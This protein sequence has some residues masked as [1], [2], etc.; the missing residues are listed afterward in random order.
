[1]SRNKNFVAVRAAYY[2]H[3]EHTK[4]VVKRQSIKQR[5]GDGSISVTTHQVPIQKTYKSAVAEIEHVSRTGATNSINV[6][7]QYSNNNAIV[8]ANGSISLID[9][10]YRCLD[11][12]KELTKRRFRSDG[13]TLFEHIVILSEGHVSRLEALYGKEKIKAEIVKSLKNYAASY[14]AQFG[15]EPLGFSLHLDEGH[16][17]ENNNFIRNVHAHVLFF[18]Y[19]FK[20]KRSN[21]KYLMK[22]GKDPVTGKTNE[23]NENFVACQDLA[24]KSFKKLKFRRGI[25]KIKTLAINLPKLE[26]MVRKVKS[27][28]QAYVLL[29]KKLAYAHSSFVRYF[30][31]WLKSLSNDTDTVMYADLA[32][33]SLFDLSDHTID[34]ILPHLTDLESSLSEMSDEELISKQ[35]NKNKRKKYD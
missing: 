17:D 23:L 18:N 26:F 4:T 27:A 6:N 16:Y 5:N 2:K 32:A 21:L 22:K 7:S 30:P 25:S 3:T 14:A 20:N 1:M 31:Q 35:I 11:R 19:D 28:R 8:F 33:S 10:Y 34:E 15:F 12:Y 24:E 13:N 9:A 29:M